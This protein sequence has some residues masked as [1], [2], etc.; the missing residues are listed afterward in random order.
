MVFLAAV[1]SQAL[2]LC[3]TKSQSSCQDFVH[4]CSPRWVVGLYVVDVDMS[5]SFSSFSLITLCDYKY[6]NHLKD[7]CQFSVSI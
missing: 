7:G 1:V 6:I 2:N 3:D 4:C 5:L